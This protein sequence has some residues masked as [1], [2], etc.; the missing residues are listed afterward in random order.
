MFHKPTGQIAAILMLLSVSSQPIIAH[1]GEPAGLAAVTQVKPASHTKIRE[2]PNRTEF[3][4]D[5]FR[6]ETKAKLSETRNWVKD[7]ARQQNFENPIRTL[8]TKVDRLQDRVKPAGR[9]IK[10]S[11]QNR[12]PGKGLMERG[13]RNFSVFGFLLIAA[14]G[15][16]VLLMS[17]AG[18]MSR[19]GGRH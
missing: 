5:A 10:A 13:E 16:V 15:T 12:I 9:T 8:E 11:L 18:P 2:A 1:A 7:T 17:L 19:L 6:H 14:F 4:I 3:S